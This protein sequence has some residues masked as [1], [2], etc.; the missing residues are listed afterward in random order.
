MKNQPGCGSTGE[1]QGKPSQ[2]CMA[3]FLFVCL[4]T[5]PALAIELWNSDSWSC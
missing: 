1:S 2:A 4:F 3:G 5:F